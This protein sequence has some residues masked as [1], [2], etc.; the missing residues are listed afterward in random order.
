MPEVSIGMP[1][2]NGAQL[3]ECALKSLL[4]QSF[5]DFELIISDNASTDATSDICQRFA[6]EDRRIRYVRQARNVGAAGNFTYV[7]GQAQAPYFMWAAHDDVWEPAFIAA[8]YEVLSTCPDVVL[9]VSQVAFVNAQGEAV[10]MGPTGTY[11]LLDSPRQNVLHYLSD[12]AQNSRYYGLH[13]TEVLRQCTRNVRCMWA[14]DW[15]VMAR[16]LKFGKHC[17]VNRCLLCAVRTG[18]VPTPGPR[19]PDS[20]SQRSFEPCRYSPIPGQCSPIP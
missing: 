17:E 3:L 20:T 16:T 15:L 5:Q 13:R 2:Y 6:R 14:D 7:L 18:I 19:L 11:P 10:D 9:S 12:P 4:H 8:N 1:V